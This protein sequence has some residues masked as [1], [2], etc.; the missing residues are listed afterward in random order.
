MNNYLIPLV[1]LYKSNKNEEDAFWAKKYMRNQFEFLG[2]KKPIREELTKKFYNEFG[3]PNID[4]LEEIILELWKLDEREFQY[5]AMG[6]IGK[7]QKKWK[8]EYIE[9]FET[10]ILEKSWWETVDWI[11]SRIIGPF[12]KQYPELKYQTTEKWINSDNIW[13]QRVCIIHQMF[14]K[15]QTDEKMLFEF[16]DLKKESNEFFIQKAIGWA[17]R[18]YSKSEPKKVL[19]FINSTKL[20][21]LSYREGI[22]IIK[23]D[24]PELIKNEYQ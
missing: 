20:K 9:L 10:L 12:F 18:Q 2:L 16:C 1:E 4:E 5:F 21:P 24:F 11:A 8:K 3:L 19:D 6:L 15:K 13:L 17:L 23:K 14:Y 7:F 22:R